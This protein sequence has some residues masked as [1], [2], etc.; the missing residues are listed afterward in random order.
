M[1]NKSMNNSLFTHASHMQDWDMPLL[2]HKKVED[3]L[4][5]LDDT[6]IIESA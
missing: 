6:S 3:Y 5:F 4:K 1:I 2:D